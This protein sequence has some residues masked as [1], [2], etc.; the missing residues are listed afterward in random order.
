VEYHQFVKY[1]KIS[2]QKCG[3]V[4]IIL[5]L[6]DFICFS[7]V[8]TRSLLSCIKFLSI[9]LGTSYCYSCAAF[10]LNANDNHYIVLMFEEVKV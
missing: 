3:I 2:T 7:M 6:I 5:E 8:I 9:I 4:V 10:F 1:S